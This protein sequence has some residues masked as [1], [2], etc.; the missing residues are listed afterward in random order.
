M[1][2]KQQIQIEQVLVGDLHPDPENPLHREGVVLS[3]ALSYQNCEQ[4]HA[5]RDMSAVSFRP[6]PQAF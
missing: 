3:T 4:A 6:H 1:Q 2:T 5:T